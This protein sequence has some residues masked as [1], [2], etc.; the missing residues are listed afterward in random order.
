MSFMIANKD[1][2]L[3]RL[4][5]SLW[6]LDIKIPK[7]WSTPHYGDYTFYHADSPPT[8][9]DEWMALPLYDPDE[10]TK[11]FVVVDPAKDGSKL[12]CTWML[13]GQY[14]KLDRRSGKEEKSFIVCGDNLYRIR[15]IM[16]W[17]IDRRNTG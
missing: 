6:N 12:V 17:H 10:D 4:P 8:L 13:G 9:K 16:G 15:G 7:G 14:V 2:R 11:W 5:G 1:G 3:R